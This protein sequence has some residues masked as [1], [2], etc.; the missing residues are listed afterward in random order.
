MIFDRDQL[1]TR[2]IKG[3]PFTLSLKQMF[4]ILL[5]F[6]RNACVNW[7]LLLTYLQQLEAK[8]TTTSGYCP[9]R[10]GKNSLEKDRFRSAHKL[11]D[12]LFS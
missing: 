1:E 6:D 8:R 2:F 12:K 3:F 11:V 9:N 7:H 5:C 10:E 4:L